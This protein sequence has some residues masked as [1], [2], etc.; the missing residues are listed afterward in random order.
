VTDSRKQ[1]SARVP[2]TDTTPCVRVPRVSFERA[3]AMG[4]STAPITSPRPLSPSD[5]CGAK[6]VQEEPPPS[7][8]S[9]TVS[10]L[11]YMY[12]YSSLPGWCLLSA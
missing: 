3:L 12:M 10:T 6:D 8:S 1:R 5:G 2:N 9:F 7:A 4:C 11:M